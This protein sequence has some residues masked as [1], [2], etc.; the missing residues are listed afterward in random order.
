MLLAK[1][2][3]S[4]QPDLTIPCCQSDFVFSVAVQ[5]PCERLE[6]SKMDFVGLMDRKKSKLGTIVC[7]ERLYM[8]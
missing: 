2:M 8:S 7:K 5:S 6:T 4:A 1:M 3:W